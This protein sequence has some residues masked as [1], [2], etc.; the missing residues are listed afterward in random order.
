MITVKNNE[1]TVEG[2]VRSV[3]WQQLNSKNGGVLPKILIVDLGSSDDTLDIIKRL[4]RDYSFIRAVSK[5]EYAQIL[6]GKRP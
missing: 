1:N 3:V 6:E 2:M 5:E 4:A